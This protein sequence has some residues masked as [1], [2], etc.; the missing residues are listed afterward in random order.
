MLE[1]PVLTIDRIPE[2]DMGRSGKFLAAVVGDQNEA[3][4]VANKLNDRGHYVSQIPLGASTLVLTTNGMETFSLE[5]PYTTGSPSEAVYLARHKEDNYEL[6]VQYMGPN[7]RTSH[8]SHPYCIELYRELMGDF[9]MYL[10]QKEIIKLRGH[11]MVR[12]NEFHVGF[13]AASPALSLIVL[14]GSDF[15]HEQKERP[16]HEF[17]VEQARLQGV[18]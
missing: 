8:H 2:I 3:D 9:F 15:Y 5:N 11:N 14:V 13:T 6:L 4:N 12:Q 18:I 10:G 16:P 17:L 7:M 1:R